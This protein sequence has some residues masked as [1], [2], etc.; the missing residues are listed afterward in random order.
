MKV[1][2]TFKKSRMNKVLTVNPAAGEIK[3]SDPEIKKQIKMIDLTENDLRII[4]AFGEVIYDQI[5]E[6]LDG[7][8]QALLE[9]PGLKSIIMK[10]STI[11]RLR[12]TLYTHIVT[13]F[14]GVIDDS[15]VEARLQVAKSH[16]RIGLA[17]RWYL[18]AFQSLQN[19]ILSLIYTYVH[20]EEEQRAVIFAITKILSFERQL[21]IQAYEVENLKAREIEYEKV[22]KDVQR[23]ILGISEEL[24]ILSEETHTSIKT[25]GF[26]GQELEDIVR[27]QTEQSTYSR[28]SAEEGQRC[29]LQLKTKLYELVVFMN[30]VDQ[31]IHSLNSSLQ[32]ITEFVQIVQS[33]ANQTN[34]LS[35]NSAIEA[36]RAGEH[37]KGFAVVANEVRK[38]ADQ[39]KE[40]IAQID[41][42]V[43]TSNGY[44]ESVLQSVVEVKEVMELGER[45]STVTVESFD[46]ILE[47][48]EKDV[49]GM[50]KIKQNMHSFV[51]VIDEIKSVTEKVASQAETLNQTAAEL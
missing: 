31:N 30:H 42:I 6:L 2:S 14:E 15:F 44:M 5:D 36:A 1:L 35:L 11:E 51:M 16:Y 7:F 20:N 17:S 24:L 48:V 50:N 37:G 47:S 41:A 43:Q 29:M 9:V 38:L 26:N 21:V 10:H 3:V 40:S 18:S 23:H 8:Y 49:V 22:K 46:K 34:L 19:S 25:L 4:F 27:I 39:T 13:L 32:Q 45:E 28:M 12:S 33:I